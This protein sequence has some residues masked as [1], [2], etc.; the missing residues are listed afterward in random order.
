M[1]LRLGWDYQDTG[2]IERGN[3]KVHFGLHYSWNTS[4]NEDSA[5]EGDP[6]FCLEASTVI[7]PKRE[8]RSF[9]MGHIAVSLY[10]ESASYNRFFCRRQPREESEC[11]VNRQAPT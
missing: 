2:I 9:N 8:E 4:S 10:N 6:G 3:N 7:G 1:V 11:L 5:C